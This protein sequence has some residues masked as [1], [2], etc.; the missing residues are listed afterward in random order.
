L[1]NK[2]TE[3]T[4]AENFGDQKGILGVVFDLPDVEIA[5][6]TRLDGIDDLD[7]KAFPPEKREQS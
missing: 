2:G 3:A 6:S 5:E 1:V 7:T 4:K